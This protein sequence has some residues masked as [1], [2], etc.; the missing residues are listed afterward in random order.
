MSKRAIHYSPSFCSHAYI[1]LS[2]GT[3]KL[4][5]YFHVTVLPQTVTCKKCLKNKKYK[6]DLLAF[7]IGYDFNV[8][9]WYKYVFERE[10]L[11]NKVQPLDF[12]TI[13]GTA[14]WISSKSERWRCE[15]V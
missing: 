13:K 7:E 11:L 5:T 14:T 15:L 6:E 12:P 3:Y 1:P 9:T 8:S 2:D 10:E 4:R